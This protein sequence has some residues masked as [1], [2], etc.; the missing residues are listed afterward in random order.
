MN[1]ISTTINYKGSPIK[2]ENGRVFARAFGT[3]IHRQNTPHWTW[4]EIEQSNMKDDFK[5][6]L[7]E[8]NLR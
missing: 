6:Y 3:T 7:N 8:N 4:Q 2:V 5:K 1:I